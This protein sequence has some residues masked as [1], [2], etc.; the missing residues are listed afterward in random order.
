MFMIFLGSALPCKLEKQISENR[1]VI[2]YGI[3]MLLTKLKW[4]NQQTVSDVQGTKC[5]IISY[6]NQKQKQQKQTIDNCGCVK[7]FLNVIFRFL[8]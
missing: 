7:D 8:L 4:K 2:W 6:K 5:Y 3:S 1:V